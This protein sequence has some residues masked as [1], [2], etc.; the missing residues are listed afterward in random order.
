MQETERIA[1]LHTCADTC[2]IS[3][4]LITP[5][6]KVDNIALALGTLSVVGDPAA[7][8]SIGSLLNM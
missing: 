4:T 6:V 1:V 2:S 5:A 3:C 8:A 7:L